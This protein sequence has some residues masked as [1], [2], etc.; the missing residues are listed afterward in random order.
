MQGV[1]ANL[2][3]TATKAYYPEIIPLDQQLYWLGSPRTT[4]PAAWC[5]LTS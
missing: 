3:V 1:P 4:R 2:V 5:R